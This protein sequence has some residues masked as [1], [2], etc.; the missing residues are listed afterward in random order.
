ML[1]ISLLAALGLAGSATL[2]LAGDDDQPLAV[3]TIA[4]HL[5]VVDPA[6]FPSPGSPP[7]PMPELPTPRLRI[8]GLDG[9]PLLDVVPFDRH[10]DPVPAA[11]DAIA[12]AFA[13]ATGDE[14]PIDPRLV[15]VLLTLSRA[16]DDRPIALVSAHRVAGRGTRK[17]SYHT[18]GMAADVA[19]RGVR[20]HDLR[21]AAVRLGAAG[22]GVY[23]GFVHIDAR[24]DE[25]YRWVGG[26]YAAWRR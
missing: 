3:H 24:K 23:P 26:T 21:A 17:T 2:A 7:I 1:A 6:R 11:F 14:A 19:I 18:K 8:E 4:E 22:V 15:E 10:G 13:P 20:V 5:P 25:P 9:R 16:F 12:A